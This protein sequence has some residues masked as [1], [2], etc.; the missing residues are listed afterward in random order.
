MNPL[1]K[2]AERLHFFKPLDYSGADIL[3][4]VNS[5]AQLNRTKACE[6]EPDTVSWIEKYIKPGDVFYDIGAN[7]GAYSLIAYT[8]GAQVFAFEPS[9]S[10]Y[11]ALC[12]N[13]L[14]NKFGITALP[15]LVGNK[16]DIVPFSYHSLD[17]GASLHSI[18]RS[19]NW[20]STPRFRLNDLITTLKLPAPTHIKIDT[21]GN[22]LAVLRG[23]DI[24]SL[25]SICIEVYETDDNTEL[26]NLLSNFQLAT[27]HARKTDGAFNYY[28]VRP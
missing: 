9:F 1:L 4:V 13:I 20:L 12:E 17:P 2:L 28:F 25:K 10:T 18:E 24:S 22:E 7:V 11:A 19:G 14:L 23:L 27:K 3:M 5:H 26:Y 6:K 16:T 21:D 8:R 15:V